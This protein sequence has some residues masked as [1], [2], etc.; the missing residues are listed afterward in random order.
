MTP[1][2]SRIKSPGFS[3]IGLKDEF[4][5]SFY[6]IIGTAELAELIAS[7]LVLYIFFISPVVLPLPSGTSNFENET[8]HLSRIKEQTLLVINNNF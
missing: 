5:V 8:V 1:A 6:N 2:D 7:L 4:N 3:K